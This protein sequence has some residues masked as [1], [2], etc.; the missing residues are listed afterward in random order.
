MW[1]AIHARD[2]AGS[3]EKRLASRSAHLVRLNEL[4]DQGRLLVAGPLPAI[5]CEDPGPAGFLG[6]LVIGNFPSLTEAREWADADP[7]FAAGVYEQVD[8]YPFKRVL[9]L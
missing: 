8:V 5:D 7:Y 9:P 6:S 2:R 1:Y 3:L 4:N